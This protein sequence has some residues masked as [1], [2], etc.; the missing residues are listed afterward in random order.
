MINELKYEDLKLGERAKEA[1]FRGESP[2]EIESKYP[3]YLNTQE[4]FAGLNVTDFA[5][6]SVLGGLNALYVGDT[7]TG[8]SQLC[9]DIFNYYFGGNIISTIEGN[10]VKIRGKPELDIYEEV[11]RDLNILEGKWVP[12]INVYAK[13]HFLDELNR[14]PP[15]TQNQFFGLGDGFLEHKGMKLPIGSNG[16][17]VTNA[18]ANLGNGEF[19]GT[20]DTDKALYSRF[21]ITIDFDYK[22]FAPTMEDRMVIDFLRA[23]N[24][25]IKE[26]P[27][28]DISSQITTIEKY[29]SKSSM[30]LGTETDAV[31]NYIKFGLENCFNEQIGGKEKNWPK[32]CQDCS[33]NSDGNTICSQ[34][35]S[36]LPR[37]IN[38]LRKYTASLDF[39]AKLKNPE[40]PFDSVDLV[41]K[42]FE[43]TGAY[44]K[45]LNPAVL[46]QTYGE[47]NPKMIKDI[48]DT[49]KSDFKANEDLIVTY[50]ELI[51][52][53]EKID[54]Y[55]G[56]PKENGSG[57]DIGPGYSQLNTKA[58]ANVQKL[59]SIID[60]ICVNNRPIGLSWVKEQGKLYKK[61]L[62]IQKSHGK[63]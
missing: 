9:Q 43:I 50:F 61:I 44:Q 25:K 41:F 17:A 32:Q 20:F 35:R 29:I 63:K 57:Y 16:Y 13:Y 34:I 11:Y 30:D 12:N 49:L 54:D 24:P 2:L 5:I 53:K 39:L 38:S 21:A 8:K 58:K 26:A 52:N 22:Q 48:V 6:A 15:V 36:P 19:G 40:I 55:F 28:R 7:G 3:I 1:Y 45:I 51:K 23:A 33:N 37:T 62:E 47:Q 56:I 42:A 14:C 27:I 31:I 59:D 46:R 4:I 10:S 18:T 60:T